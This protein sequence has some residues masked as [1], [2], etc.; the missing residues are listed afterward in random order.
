V[1]KKKQYIPGITRV[2]VIEPESGH[3]RL[4]DAV[5][6]Q[7]E[8]IIEIPEEVFYHHQRIIAEY[9]NCM[10]EL[11]NDYRNTLEL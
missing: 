1:D 4:T 9:L 11:Q 10:K 6:P 5:H 7:D 2:L 8:G 3:L